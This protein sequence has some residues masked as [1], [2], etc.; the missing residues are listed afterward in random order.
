MGGGMRKTKQSR[1]NGCTM[2]VR[3]RKTPLI[4]LL[5]PYSVLVRTFIIFMVSYTV[6]DNVMRTVDGYIITHQ[7]CVVLLHTDEFNLTSFPA[8]P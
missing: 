4:K 5:S 3:Y 8:V 7:V 2:R 6:S 1:K